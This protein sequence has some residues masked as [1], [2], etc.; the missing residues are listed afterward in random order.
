MNWYHRGEGRYVEY[1]TSFRASQSFGLKQLAHGHDLQHEPRAPVEGRADGVR[2]ARRR[3]RAH[4][5][6][7][8]PDVPRPPPPRGVRRHRADADRVDRVP[9]RGRT[10]RRS[11]S[12]P[13]SS[14]RAGR[15][16]ARSSGCRACATSTPAASASTW[17]STTCSTSCCSRC[18]TTTRTRT[19]TGRSRRS[20]S[21]AAADRQLER[22][23]EPAGGPEAFLEDHAVIVCSDHSQ[24]RGGGGDRPVPARSTASTCCP[25]RAAAARRRR[26]RGVPELA[27][28]AG[29]RARPRPPRASWCRGS[30]ARC[31]RSRAST[32]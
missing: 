30:S 18:P 26:D 22:M 2:A 7:D 24:S 23:M 4:G 3:Q 25:P 32:S 5:R 16:A 21:L 20:T 10:A 9:A 14:R 13:T 12:T 8:V 19:S 28:R 6:H 29:L 31:S 1:G 17:S 11:C 27:R 15:R